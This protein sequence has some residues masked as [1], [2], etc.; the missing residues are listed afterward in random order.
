MVFAGVVH[1]EVDT[2]A[3]TQAVA[4]VTQGRQILHGAQLRLDFAEVGNGI[5]AVASVLGALQQRHQVEIVD[6]AFLDIVKM[7]PDAL[8]VAREAV[9][10]HEHAQHLI[11]LIPVRH[12]LSG[13]VPVFQKRA[14]L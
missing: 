14:A 10:I 3:H 9:G 5:A 12:Q 6:A 2:D 1:N 8:Q 4:F 11:S 13:L 7:L